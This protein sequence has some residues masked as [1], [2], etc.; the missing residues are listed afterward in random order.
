MRDVFELVARLAQVW[1]GFWPP[2]D[3]ARLAAA[4]PFWNQVFGHGFE[5]S[6]D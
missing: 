1:K 6:V 2:F 3:G 4:R 5:Q